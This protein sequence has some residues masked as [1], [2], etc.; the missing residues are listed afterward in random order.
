[1]HT[2]TGNSSQHFPTPTVTPSGSGNLVLI[3]AGAQLDAFTAS[4]RS[5]LT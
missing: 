3:A 1:V 2:S 5:F 4:R